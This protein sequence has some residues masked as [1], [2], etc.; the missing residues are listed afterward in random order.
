MKNSLGKSFFVKN[1]VYQAKGD[2]DFIL[3]YRR[4]NLKDEYLLCLAKKT[5]EHK[6]KQKTFP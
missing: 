4:F 2:I 6:A 1:L 3:R 5:N